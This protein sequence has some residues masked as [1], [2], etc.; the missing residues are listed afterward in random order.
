MIRPHRL[1][2]R[3][4]AL[5]IVDIQE[6][7][8]AAMGDGPQVEA[9]ALRLARAA[10]L[11]GMPRFA[12]EQNPRGLGPT[13]PALA[14]LLPSRPAKMSFSC[15]A[16]PELIEGL[17]GRGVRHVALAGL[18]AHV[19]VLQTALDLMHM[20]FTVAVVADAVASRFPVD[21]EFALR[22]LEWAGAIV[23]TTETLLFEW[24]ETADSPHFRAIRALVTDAKPTEPNPK[25]KDR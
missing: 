22:R 9:N 8:L 7:L 12:T 3:H 19:C 24:T 4:G 23:T 14:R 18:E 1:T 21:R 10:E 15:C 16:V 17:H 20:G 2:A 25:S 6:R 5:L 13:V 11:L